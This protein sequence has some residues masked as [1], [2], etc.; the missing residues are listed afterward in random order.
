VSLLV[1]SFYN[2]ACMCEIRMGFVS[3]V[4][5]TRGLE[6]VHNIVAW[7]VSLAGRR[8]SHLSDELVSFKSVCV[9]L[10][11]GFAYAESGDKREDHQKV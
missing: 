1:Q 5:V 8:F 10:L 4:L 3:V 9:I 7:T 6:Y 2:D 11:C